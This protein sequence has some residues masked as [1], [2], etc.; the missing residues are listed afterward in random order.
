MSSCS[1]KLSRF[2]QCNYTLNKKALCMKRSWDEVAAILDRACAKK[3]CS[4]QKKKQH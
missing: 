3:S 1:Q 4:S 2:F